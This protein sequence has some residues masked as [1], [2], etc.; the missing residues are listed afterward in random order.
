MHQ[1]ESEFTL[2]AL[3]SMTSG[4]QHNANAPRPDASGWGTRAMDRP[5]TGIASQP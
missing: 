2:G 1:A 5:T 3:L 4:A